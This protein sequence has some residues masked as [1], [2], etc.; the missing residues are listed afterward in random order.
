MYNSTCAVAPSQ[1]Q[2]GD[3]IIRVPA[4]ILVKKKPFGMFQLWSS[5]QGC[6]SNCWLPL[7][8]PVRA[9]PVASDGIL[10][11]TRHSCVKEGSSDSSWEQNSSCYLWV[12]KVI[13][14]W[15]V[16]SLS[17]HKNW[18][19]WDHS[20]LILPCQKDPKMFWKMACTKMSLN[21]YIFVCTNICICILYIKCITYIY[22]EKTKK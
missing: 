17:R 15:D 10:Q 22:R 3:A 8:S 19:C 4:E 6:S 5:I 7:R 21:I 14:L 1:L 18:L 9:Q 11:G 12:R 2:G 16:E 20:Q 13:G